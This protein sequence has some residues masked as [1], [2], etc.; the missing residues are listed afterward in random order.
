MHGRFKK[1]V[2][3]LL[4]EMMEGVRLEIEKGE[5]YSRLKHRKIKLGK[6][7]IESLPQDKQHLFFEYEETANAQSSHI[8]DYVYRKGIFHGVRISGFFI[9]LFRL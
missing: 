5:R 7:L 1:Y 6:Q 2:S 3:V 8:E 9:K 4:D